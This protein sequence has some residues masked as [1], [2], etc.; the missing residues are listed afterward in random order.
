MELVVVVE[1][2]RV[3]VVVMLGL[4]V[5]EVMVE[6]VS[7]PMPRMPKVHPPVRVAIARSRLLWR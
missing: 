5:M 7:M 1:W 3:V 4:V 2:D 6:M